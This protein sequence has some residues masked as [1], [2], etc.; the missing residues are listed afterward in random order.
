MRPEHESLLS[1]PQTTLL[2]SQLPSIPFRDIHI[3]ILH[4]DA[5]YIVCLLMQLNFEGNSI[6][7]N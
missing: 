1:A 2:K 3:M 4:N 7:L 6:S 5:V